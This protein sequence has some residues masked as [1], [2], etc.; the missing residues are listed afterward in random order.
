MLNAPNS[1]SR[2]LLDHS[3]RIY[4]VLVGQL[5]GQTYLA[6]PTAAIGRY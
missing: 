2:P 5:R 6:P 4:A 1:E 3:G